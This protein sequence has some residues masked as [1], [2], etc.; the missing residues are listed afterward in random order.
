[1]QPP[2]VLVATDFSESSHL[3]LQYAAAQA[4]VSGAGLLI[5]H[6]EEV[7]TATGEGMLHAGI[8]RE[9]P[10]EL[11]RRLEA[12]VPEDFGGPCEHLLLEGDP[13]GEIVRA[14]EEENASLIVLGTH[15]RTGLARLLMGSVAEQVVRHAPCPVLIVKDPALARKG[16]RAG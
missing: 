1:M 4:R 3:A 13:A 5:V 12:V 11:E 10:E 6:V 14:A 7:S 9:D 8:P 16:R 2:T 15:G